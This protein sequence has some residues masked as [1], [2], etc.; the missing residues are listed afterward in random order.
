[1]AKWTRMKQLEARLD[2]ME[3]GLRQTQDQLED[4]FEKMEL[5]LRQTQEEVPRRECCHPGY[6]VDDG[7]K[8]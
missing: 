1:M 6:D 7:A 5:G 8:C 3:S 4:R 2:M